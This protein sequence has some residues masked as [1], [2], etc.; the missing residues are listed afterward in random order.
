[1]IV[2][3]VISIISPN[4]CL[5]CHKPG[6]LVCASCQ[7]SELVWRTPACFLC[8]AL[9]KN[10][11]TCTRC[12]N[13][14]RLSGVTL[15]FR[16]I[17]PMKNIIYELKYFGN[18]DIARWLPPYL[19]AELVSSKFDY[20]SY[21]PAT[22]QSQR[23]RGYN[24]AHLLAR[25]IAS[26]VKIPLKS[27]LLRLHHVDQIGL[28]RMQRFES[29]K[30]N[31]ISRGDLSGKNIL[32]VDDVL[33]TGATLSECARVLKNAGAKKVWGLAVAKK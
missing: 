5:V 8:N 11:Q 3:K 19:V 16:L 1:M 33:T 17:G 14:S 9:T 26:I 6:E 21:V 31:F 10:G 7:Q 20:I 24:Q 2:E 27:T 32:L 4:E 29:V 28:G 23:Q 22:G 18:R 13:K 30:N 25:E 15:P 12:R